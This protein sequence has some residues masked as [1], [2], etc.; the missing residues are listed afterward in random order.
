MEQHEEQHETLRDMK[1]EVHKMMI[2]SNVEYDIIG[3]WVNMTKRK[4]EG[5]RS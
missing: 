1:Y 2:N 3:D 4:M 5:I